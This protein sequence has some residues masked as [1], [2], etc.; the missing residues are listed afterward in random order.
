MCVRMDVCQ[1]VC[2]HAC[3]NPG[4]P[5]ACLFLSYQTAGFSPTKGNMNL[6]RT[7]L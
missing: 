7:Y 2:L 1:R 6:C 5:H 3:E 4:I